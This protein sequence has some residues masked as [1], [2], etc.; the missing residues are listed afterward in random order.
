MLGRMREFQ[1]NLDLNQANQIKRITK[2][3]YLIWT[4]IDKTNELCFHG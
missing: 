3:S 4:N 2:I 1:N